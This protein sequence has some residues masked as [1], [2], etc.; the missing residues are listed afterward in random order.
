[1]PIDNQ[2]T[3]KNKVNLQAIL[4]TNRYSLL[5]FYV[6]LQNTYSSH[7]KIINI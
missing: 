7:K 6:V 2:M 1:M 5:T 3:I 4:I